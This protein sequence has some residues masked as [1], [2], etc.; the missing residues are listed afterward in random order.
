[1]NEK[2]MVWLPNVFGESWYNLKDSIQRS[3]GIDICCIDDRVA[4]ILGEVW[5]GKAKDFKNVGYLIIGTGVGL[6]IMAEGKIIKGHQNVAGSVGWISLDS[7]NFKIPGYRYPVTIENFISG[8]AILKRFKASC[9]GILKNTNSIFELYDKTKDKC[10]QVII[11]ETSIVLGKLIAIIANILNPE[12]IIFGGS[13]GKKWHHFKKEALRI[14]ENESSPLVRNCHMEVS[15]LGENAQ[16]I[17]CTK[18]ILDQ[19]R[20]S[21]DIVSI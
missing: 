20:G 7:I 13:I 18:Y 1:V 15:E 3:I 12:L 19:I 6:G 9:G 21:D 16:I 2:E 4:G 11:K 5:K 8:P 17:G 10:A 14:F